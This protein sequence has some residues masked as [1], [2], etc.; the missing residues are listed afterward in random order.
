[1]FPEVTRGFVSAHSPYRLINS[2]EKLSRRQSEI[3]PEAAFTGDEWIR[4]P[5][6]PL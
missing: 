5:T 4:Q 6:Q 2:Q 3:A 1:M